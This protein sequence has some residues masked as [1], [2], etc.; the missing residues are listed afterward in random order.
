MAEAV[1]VALRPTA[2]EDLDFVLALE[3]REDYAAYIFRW[4]REKHLVALD[5]GDIRHLMICGSENEPLGY[6]LLAGAQ[7]GAGSIELLRIALARPG[8]GVGAAAL[9]A[10]SSYAFE[11]LAA[12]RFWLDV[13]EDNTRARRAYLRAGFLEEA[14]R[15]PTLQRLG[16]Q[17]PLVVMSIERKAFLRGGP[18]FQA[19]HR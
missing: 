6:A 9:S 19:R 7:R 1:Q 12:Q 15:R 16:E 4:P 11:K 8:R 14:G 3:A 10:L 2:P 18:E 13:F 17:V 5:D